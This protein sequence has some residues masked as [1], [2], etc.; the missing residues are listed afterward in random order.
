VTKEP[1]ARELLEAALLAFREGRI[2]LADVSHVLAL[3]G[4][5]ALATFEL[6]HDV[7]RRA[8]NRGDGPWTLDPV[9]ARVALLKPT[10]RVA[11]LERARYRVKQLE[12]AADWQTNLIAEWGLDGAAPRS[13]FEVLCEDF[14]KELAAIDSQFAKLSPQVVGQHLQQT[15]PGNRPRIGAPRLIARL[16]VACGAFGAD[17][18][19]AAVGAFEQAWRE[20]RKRS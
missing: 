13:P 1:D 15:K 9:G 16:S 7:A 19:D 2:S 5:P 11:A 20:S 14:Q 10:A 4:E 18:E 6:L 8:A 3:S 12:G 17:N